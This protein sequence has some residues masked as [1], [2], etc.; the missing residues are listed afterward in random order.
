MAHVIIGTGSY[1]PEQVQTNHDIE[2]MDNDWAPQ[3]KGPATLHEWAVT[4]HG[5]VKRHRVSPGECNSDLAAQ[6]CRN[7]LSD[8]GLDVKDIDLIVMGT[9]TAD[10]RMSSGAGAVQAK[11]GSMAKFIQVDAAC[12]GFVDALL[13]AEGMLSTGRYKTALVVAVDVTS[14]IL[15]P[16]TF[17]PWTIFGDGAGAVVLQSRPSEYGIRGFATGSEGAL[18]H[19]AQIRGG[20]SK[21]PFSEQVLRDRTQYVEFK[22]PLIH[23]WAID[24]FVRGVRESTSAAGIELADVKWVIPHQ[25][26]NNLMHQLSKR[27]SIPFDKF[28]MT[29]EQTGNTSAASVAIA[30]DYAN[31]ANQ[32]ADGDW[33]VM[34]AAGT[35][36][37]WGAVAYRWF[38]YR[39]ERSVSAD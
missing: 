28:Y 13:V 7:A 32:L 10:Q 34:P 26:S 31:K 23:K 36:L 16:Q 27:L 6:A 30:L 12:S 29:Y 5:A 8:A 39:A 21:L 25:A 37:Q 9:C 2:A 18:G 11:I 35:G 24:H 4:K 33:L 22:F 17:V 19:Y 20:G 14:A 3:P 15:D 1:L 38:D